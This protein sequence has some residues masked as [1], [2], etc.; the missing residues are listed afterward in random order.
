M[1]ETTFFKVKSAKQNNPEARSTLDA[2]HHQK[3]G[4]LQ[5]EKAKVAEYMKEI[6][7][8]EKKITETS[9]DIEIWRLEQKVEILKKKVKHLFWIFLEKN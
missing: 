7:V 1:S 4:Q 5:C 8:L 9:S 2:I 6:T 3:I